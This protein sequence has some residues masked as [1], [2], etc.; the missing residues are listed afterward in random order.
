MQIIS[1]KD[2]ICTHDVVLLAPNE[3]NELLSTLDRRTS[4]KMT[5]FMIIR[6]S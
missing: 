2:I 5:L 6:M 1:I 4:F 3:I